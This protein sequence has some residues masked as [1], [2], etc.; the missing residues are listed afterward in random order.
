MAQQWLRCCLIGVVLSSPLLCDAKE[1]LME[2]LGQKNKVESTH[3]TSFHKLDELI[4]KMFDVH[5]SIKMHQYM[6]QGAQSGIESAQW[7]YFPTPTLGS[8]YTT[9]HLD[10]TTVS[11]SQPLWTGG[12]LDAMYDMALA[13][14]EASKY[15]LRESGYVL[16]ETLLNALHT[17]LKAKEDLVALERGRE[18]FQRLEEM[19]V[20]REDSGVSSKADVELLRARIYQLETNINVARSKK[21]VALGQLEL[22]TGET[23]T[24]E[25]DIKNFE[26]YSHDASVDMVKTVLETHPSLEKIDA[27]VEYAKAERE[28]AKAAILP[29]ISL[30]AQK[31]FGSTSLYNETNEN[32]TVVYLAI[33]ANPG[34]GLS[35]LSAKEVAEAKVMQLLQDKNVK[36]HDLMDKIILTYNNYTF[37]LSRMD[38]QS[39]SVDANQNV[40]DSYIR[41]FL[42]GKRQWLDLMSASRELTDNELSFNDTKITY[43][44]ASYQLALLNGK[45]NSL[46]RFDHDSVRK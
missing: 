4:E 11:L 21:A 39:K 18:R 25:L 17:Y 5:P 32:D 28:K 10:S 15:T 3:S 26:A 24:H 38:I 19:I 7:N 30:K 12:K 1:S 33:E 29:T 2:T 20:R 13:N 8:N 37:A 31:I 6:I 23:F 34:A 45:F 36:K 43:L 14:K 22:L 42:T 46:M 35:S 44:M 9:K 41:L 27:Q 40:F 16:I